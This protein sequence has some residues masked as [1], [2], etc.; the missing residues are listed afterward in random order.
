MIRTLRATP[1]E[2]LQIKTFISASPL[3]HVNALCCLHRVVEQVVTVICE[4]LRMHH[5]PRRG[6]HFIHEPRSSGYLLSGYC[7][8]T[9]AVLSLT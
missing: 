2:S 5:Q 7:T 9:I 3:S 1:S 4:G 6:S 8:S